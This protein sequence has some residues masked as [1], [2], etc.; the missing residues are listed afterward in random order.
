MTTLH[1]PLKR[2]W[3]DKIRSGFKTEEYRDLN[4]FWTKRLTENPVITKDYIKPGKPKKFDSVVF[5]CGYPKK[6]DTSRRIEFR[7][8]KIEVRYG[9]EEWGAKKDFVY[10]VI[11]WDQE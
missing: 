2:E 9:Q 8:P 4:E 5:T 6:T 1:L 10:F 7:N 3:F 11:T